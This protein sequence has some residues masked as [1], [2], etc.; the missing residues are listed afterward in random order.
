M[1][2][3]II[4]ITLVLIAGF[5]THWGGICAVAAAKQLVYFGRFT[6][7][8][9][10]IMS[11]A[12]S[13]VVIMAGGISGFGVFDQVTGRLWDVHAAIG[14]CI[15]GIGAWING[16]CAFGTVAHLG[17]GELN[18]LGTILGFCAGIWISM[19]LGY[20][21]PETIMR[22]P[23]LEMIDHRSIIF[24]AL[25]TIFF[26]AIAFKLNGGA[27]HDNPSR[28]VVALAIIG[29]ISGIM[30]MLQQNWPYTS[31][32]IDLTKS[33]GTDLAYRSAL[34]ILFVVGATFGAL[35]V[36][37]FRVRFGKLSHWARSSFGGLLMGLGAAA[38]PGG[39]DAM[40]FLGTPFQFPNL[41][42]AALTMG[43]TLIALAFAKRWSLKRQSLS[44]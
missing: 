25:A 15:F 5:A 37:K 4:A 11:A 33:Q 44:A 7:V 16:R 30:L 6:L 13:T 42:A 26:A 36:G 10:M 29:I 18:R 32:L 22:S 28:P 20:E 1:Q 39:N 41:I 21:A 17:Q 8:S 35:A 43:A 9:G 23:L 19:T 14:G 34:S 2:T 31:L 3:I 27:G 24:A 40:L 38:I 12:I